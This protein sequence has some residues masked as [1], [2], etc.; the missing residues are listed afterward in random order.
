[1]IVSDDS[2]NLGKSGLV[3]IC[4]LTSKIAKSVSILA[5]IRVD[6]PTGGLKV[7]SVILCD[8]VRAISVDRLIPPHW[9]VLDAG[10]LSK[11]ETVVRR[12]LAL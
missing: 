2:L 4:P 11:V 1:V 3:V 6:P 10:T 8:Q 5:H 12:L 7:P 9:G